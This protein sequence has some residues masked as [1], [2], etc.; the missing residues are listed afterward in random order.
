MKDIQPPALR[1]SDLMYLAVKRLE[2]VAEK[3][4]RL[5]YDSELEAH[6]RDLDEWFQY[7]LAKRFPDQEAK[8]TNHEN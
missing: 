7:I 3:M 2:R 4:Q 1:D 5:E 6:M 8:E